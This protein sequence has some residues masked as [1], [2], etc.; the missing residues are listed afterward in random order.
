MD[1]S[2]DSTHSPVVSPQEIISKWLSVEQAA[3]HVNLSAQTIR[4]ILHSGDLRATQIGHVYRIER[5]DLDSFMARRKRSVRPYRRG[6]KPYVA[7]RHAENRRA[8]P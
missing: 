4:N 2:K 6:S 8:R 5:S 1:L 3:A 7:K